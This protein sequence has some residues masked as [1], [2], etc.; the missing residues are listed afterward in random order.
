MN[1][2]VNGNKRPSTAVPV[3]TKEDKKPITK[4]TPVV[5]PAFAVV[6][7]Q[8]ATNAT[9]TEKKE[10]D[11]K[12]HPVIPHK[13]TK[14]SVKKDES[15]ADEE[16]KT[17]EIK[18][19]EKKPAAVVAA[20]VKKDADKE[21][22]KPARGSVTSSVPSTTE[23][24]PTGTPKPAVK[25]ED[26]KAKKVREYD[27]DKMKYRLIMIF[28]LNNKLGCCKGNSYCSKR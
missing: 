18:K 11:D 23:K 26:P 19:I 4:P 27:Q 22:K 3:E 7:S 6:R 5:K 15:K 8:T 13:T 12:K 17:E 25:K 10:E 16:K 1:L 9:T 28:I 24:K 14:T 2:A 20:V 21:D